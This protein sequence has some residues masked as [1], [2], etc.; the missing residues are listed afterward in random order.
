MAAY[1]S[2]V[3]PAFERSPRL[4]GFDQHQSGARAGAELHPGIAAYPLERR[5][6]LTLN[7]AETGLARPAG[8]AGP[9]VLELEARRQ[10]R[11]RATTSM[12]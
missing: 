9:V 4:G 11:L 5:F 3:F 10:P 7:A 8:E 2:A 12:Y 6:D 1:P